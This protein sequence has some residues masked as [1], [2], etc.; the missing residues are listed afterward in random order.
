MNSQQRNRGRIL[1]PEGL[2]RLQRAIAAWELQH[3]VR[4]T[5]EKLRELTIA[6]KPPNGLDPGTIGKIL[7]AQKGVDPKSIRCLFKTLGLQL[8]E[9]DLISSAR[10]QVQADPNFVGREGAIADLNLLVERGAKVIVIQARGGVGKTTLARK[11]LQQEFGSYLEFPIAKETKDIA[12]IESLLEEKL[13]QLGEE[14]GREFFVSLDRLKRKLQAE[15]IGILI[16]NLEPALDSTGKL[17]EPHRRYVELLRVVADP[18]V[19][20]TTLITTR[21]RLR[22]SSITV[23]HYI[24]KSLDIIAW[25]QFFQSRNL[26]IDT[27]AFAALH[28][29]Y[30]GNA[31]AMEIIR[32]AI[33]EDYSGDVAAY[34]HANQNDLFIERDLEDLVT[35]QFDRLQQIDLDAYHLLCRMGCYRYQDV[36]TVPIG[37][38]LCLLWDV[39]ENRQ[40][41]I[42][43]ALQDRS[44]VES[45][46]REY[47]LHPIIREEAINRLRKS[48]DL[49][50][51][52]SNSAA[53]WT[54]NVKTIESV[55][56]ALRAM[57]AYYHYVQINDFEEATSI[58]IRERHHKWEGGFSLGRS[59]GY[60]MYGFGLLLK[61]RTAVNTVIQYINSKLLL[62]QLYLLLGDLHWITG[63][64]QKGIEYLRESRRLVVNL[65]L[66]KSTN[67]DD[68]SQLKGI[69]ANAL[70]NLGLCVIS[71][72][73][74]EQA[75]RIFEQLVVDTENTV[76]HQFTIGAWTCL[77]SLNSLL[78]FQD[79][80]RE[81][82]V[83]AQSQMSEIKG[84]WRKS[85]APIHLGNT[86]KNLGELERAT[87]L[88][89]EANSFAEASGKAHSK[90]LALLGLAE[91]YREK[92]DLELSILYNLE[93]IK[94]FCEIGAKP[95][96]A[97]AYYQLGLSYQAI[98]EVEN[99][100]KYF[101]KAI[102]LF[103]QMEA[104]KQVERV[105]LSMVM[106]IDAIDTNN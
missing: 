36:P 73:E 94:K 64:I 49:E 29:A 31:K 103:L 30:G 37:G 39:P 83:K 76:N 96:L 27:P 51:T 1:T 68:Y 75:V 10:L 100:N 35:Q 89:F 85:Y 38:L 79:R 91:V 63:D 58:I 86:Y 77:A 45:E 78:G 71:L 62:G 11:Y 50:I 67:I 55:E 25:E 105:R 44:L 47:W 17:I 19:Q 65:L 4:C 84:S 6:Q 12:S 72:G 70:F 60:A 28:N 93:A 53:F 101:Q 15:R 102:H 14:P 61:I 69:E 80:A 90:S 87:E 40:G 13:R 106:Y 56:D 99:S 26:E 59:L 20:S 74:L 18:S 97:E 5:Q 66:S 92:K 82:V 42:V 24:L 43:R 16:D 33:L 8:D 41:R 9:A 32:G 21:E 23:E 57:E 22:E 34:W 46:D 95:D 7:E 104:P 98:G 2:S 54:G 3:E 81:F 88:Y 52:Y 48:K